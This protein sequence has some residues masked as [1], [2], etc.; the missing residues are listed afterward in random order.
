MVFGC[1][2]KL[3]KINDVLISIYLLPKKTTRTELIPLAY[4]VKS[5]R[6]QTPENGFE[7]IGKNDIIAEKF[8]IDD[9]TVYCV[10][11]PLSVLC[12]K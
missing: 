10:V 1:C 7:L 6:K 11:R 2:D 5:T 3:K 9:D 4:I 12:K 8:R